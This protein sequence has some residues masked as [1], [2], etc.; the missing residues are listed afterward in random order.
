VVARLHDIRNSDKARR[1]GADEIVSPD[2]TGGMRIASAM[3]RPHVVNFMDQMLRSDD[4]LRV[5][6]V[7]VPA[8]FAPRSVGAVIPRS[9][10]YVLMATHERGQWVFNPPDDHMLQ[11]GTAIV[12]MTNPGARE[13]LESA[14]RA[15]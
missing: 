14:L 8:G 4:H 5:E 11:P 2:F 7:L 1:A 9:R 15:A 3:V 10:D 13:K 12:L 6:E